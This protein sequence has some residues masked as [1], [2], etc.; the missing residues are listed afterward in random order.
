MNLDKPCKECGSIF[1]AILPNGPHYGIYCT[2]GH[3]Q[4]WIKK[5]EMIALL[6]IEA[7][8]KMRSK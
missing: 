8:Y 5:N 2:N 7:T 1:G 3:W 6:S 4:K